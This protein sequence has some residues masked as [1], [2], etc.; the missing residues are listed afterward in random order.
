M[1][2]ITVKTA[3]NTLKAGLK[4]KFSRDIN[5]LDLEIKLMDIL[6][7]DDILGVEGF[8]SDGDQELDFDLAS[9]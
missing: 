8:D 3:I 4:N 7:S 5:Q 9:F 1:P 2:A 6:D